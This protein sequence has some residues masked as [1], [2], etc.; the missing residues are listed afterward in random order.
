MR[1]IIRLKKALGEE[2]RE[3]INGFS[4]SILY[5]SKC[6]PVIGVESNCFEEIRQ[7]SFVENIRPSVK[8]FFQEGSFL[9]TII[10]QPSLKKSSLV[11]NQLLGW[12]DVR[13][14]VLDSGVNDHDIKIVEHK[15]FTGTGSN[16]IENHGT[17]V[18]KIVKH[19]ARGVN[20]YSGKIGQQ[21]P[22]ELNLMRAIEWAVFEK[23]ANI[24]NISSGFKRDKSC[25]GSCDLCSLINAVANEGVAV[26]VA[27]GNNKNV[28]DSIDCPGVADNAITVGAVDADKKIAKYSSFGSVEGVKPNI[29]APGSGFLDADYF[30]GTSFA[31]PVVAGSIAAI[32]GRVGTISKAVEYIYKTVDDLGLPKHQQGLGCINLE[33]LVEVINNE[34]PNSKSEEQESN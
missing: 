4:S 21:E 32:L 1:Y 31:S 29:V 19:M 22:D 12:G 8:G 20:L 9:S 24:L 18:A 17:I 16:D 11:N 25:D 33:R 5:E 6:L 2:E 14:G 26:V 30:E 28:K 27:A 15:D 10:F 23:G 3:Q 34:T 7:L 13:V